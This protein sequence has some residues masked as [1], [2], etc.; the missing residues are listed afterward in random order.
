MN[1]LF[2]I[3]IKLLLNADDSKVIPQLF[4]Q[5]LRVELPNTSMMIFYI[6]K[7]LHILIMPIRLFLNQ[8]IKLWL[9]AVNRGRTRSFP[10]LYIKPFRSSPRKVKTMIYHF[11]NIVYTS[12]M[13]LKHLLNCTLYPVIDT[14]HHLDLIPIH[15]FNLSALHH[16]TSFP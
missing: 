14:L 9:N 7:I 11:E 10:T 5:W 13:I 16:Q 1:M 4:L 3:Q 2:F 8:H 12:K 6:Q 15:C